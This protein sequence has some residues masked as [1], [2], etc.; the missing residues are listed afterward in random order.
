M[1]LITAMNQLCTITPDHRLSIELTYLPPLRSHEEIAY[2]MNY[3]MCKIQELLVMKEKI[4]IDLYLTEEL[5]MERIP[6]IK[7]FFDLFKRELPNKLNQFRLYTKSKYK[8]FAHLF[9]TFADRETKA[10]M[11]I[12]GL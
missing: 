8:G 5:G 7:R 4:D 3:V 12:I 2:C 11:E 6:T 10:R 1:E 9:L